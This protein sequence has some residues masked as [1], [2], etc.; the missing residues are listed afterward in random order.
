MLEKAEQ[1]SKDLGLPAPSPKV[2]VSS[3][4]LGSET[5][6]NALSQRNIEE[7]QLLTPRSTTKLKRQYSKDVKENSDS[8]VEINITAPS[9][10]L[11]RRL[12]SNFFVHF[13]T[14]LFI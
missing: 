8:S 3:T 2:T 9:N 5:T 12:Y 13:L 10:V 14:Y 6:R 7:S 4:D 11:V 1:R